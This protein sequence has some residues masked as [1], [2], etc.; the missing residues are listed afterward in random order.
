[1]FERVAFGPELDEG[2]AWLDEL[3]LPP[4]ERAALAQQLVQLGVYRKLVRGTLREAI[5]LA[6]PRTIAR[7]GSL[8]DEY[9]ERFL[10]ARGPRSHYLRDVTTELLAFC[11]PLW[12]E[13]TRVP[14]WA[15]DL[16]RHE[17]LRIEI[18]AMPVGAAEQLGELSL[19]RALR[20]SEAS[21]VVRYAFAVHRLSE[22]ERDRRE[23]EQA[24]TALF[25]YRSPEHEVRYLELS[26]A[27]AAILERL[28]GGQTLG[29]ALREAA[30]ALG[31]PLD[32]ALLEGTARVLADLAERG[33]LLGACETTSPVLKISPA[34]RGNHERS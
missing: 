28:H 1:L 19:D 22:D 32:D 21:R 30:A 29:L 13:D 24:A 9:F 27:A 23:P 15:H 3:E 26:A 4:G 34:S 18:G 2:G 14:R 12:L 20:F 7:L 5:E 25:V 6:I 16:S 31:V 33:A 10:A 11:A 8:F 17:A